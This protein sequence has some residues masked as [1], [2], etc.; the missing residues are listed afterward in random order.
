MNAGK[1]QKMHER[2][3]L[4]QVII[5]GIVTE[6]AVNIKTSFSQFRNSLKKSGECLIQLIFSPT[7]IGACQMREGVCLQFIRYR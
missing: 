5:E 7:I 3:L 2:T 6:S 4:S 1:T